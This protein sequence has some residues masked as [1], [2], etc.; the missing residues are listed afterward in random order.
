VAKPPERPKAADDKPAAPRHDFSLDPLPV[1]DATESDGDTAWGLWQQT[2]QA[3]D[4]AAD[5]PHTDF[6]D[7]VLSQDTSYGTLP[8][9][10]KPDGKKPG[11]PDD[12]KP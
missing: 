8:S 12:K 7:T 6:A 10:L 3:N 5:P 4:E 11:K 1:P 2:L 9:E